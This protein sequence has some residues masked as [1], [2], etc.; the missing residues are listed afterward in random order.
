[1]NR[2]VLLLTLSLT[3]LTAGVAVADDR[4]TVTNRSGNTVWCAVMYYVPKDTTRRGRSRSEP[5]WM[6]RGW[7]KLRPGQR[8]VVYTGKQRRIFIHLRDACGNVVRP[9]KFDEKKSYPVTLNNAFTTRICNTEISVKWWLKSTSGWVG[10]TYG[11]LEDLTKLPTPKWT[12]VPFYE[13]R[14]AGGFV[15]R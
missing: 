1:M 2:R 9:D 7:W 3:W 15:I 14:T 13:I 5:Y 11:S 10:T 12:L 4:F 6:I 8:E